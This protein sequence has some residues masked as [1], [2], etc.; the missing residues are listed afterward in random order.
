M[1]KTGVVQVITRGADVAFVID[2]EASFDVVAEE[3][4]EYLSKQEG[5]PVCLQPN[6]PVLP[7]A[8]VVSASLSPTN[9]VASSI[10]A[11]LSNY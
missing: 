4:R 3:L 8:S 11:T 6:P 10:F 2:E 9:K 5:T 7:Q 1:L